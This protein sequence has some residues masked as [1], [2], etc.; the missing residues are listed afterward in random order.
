MKN[1]PR[2]KLTFIQ[3]QP[4]KSISAVVHRQA[5][6]YNSEEPATKETGLR[7]TATGKIDF[8]SRTINKQ[9]TKGI[10]HHAHHSDLHKEQIGEIGCTDHT[11]GYHN[12]FKYSSLTKAHGYQSQTT[13]KTSRDSRQGLKGKQTRD[14]PRGANYLG[15]LRPITARLR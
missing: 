2:K 3:R 11:Y 9:Y 15:E 8:P 5:G 12:R 6:C 13:G 4:E 10:T 14:F 1:Q 7:P